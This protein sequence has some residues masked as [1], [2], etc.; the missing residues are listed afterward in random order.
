MFA[1]VYAPHHM[2][3]FEIDFNTTETTTGGSGRK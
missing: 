3:S 1:K 2:V